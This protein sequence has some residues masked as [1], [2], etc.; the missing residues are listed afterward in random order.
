MPTDRVRQCHRCPAPATLQLSTPDGA[1]IYCTAHF[2]ALRELG[3]HT[4]VTR[5]GN[6]N[7]PLRAV[8]LA[9]TA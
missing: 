2:L 5:I 8:E 7:A 1:R 4:A 6:R 9:G 3:P